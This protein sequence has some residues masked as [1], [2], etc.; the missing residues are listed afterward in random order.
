M[1]DCRC[2]RHGY[3][4]RPSLPS[5]C[6][7]TC[8]QPLEATTDRLPTTIALPA[9]TGNTACNYHRY[10]TLP[11]PSVILVGTNRPSPSQSLFLSHYS[12]DQA[13]LELPLLSLY[14]NFRDKLGN[15]SH[16][17]PKLK[18]YVLHICPSISH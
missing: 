18:I 10:S 15:V 17:A 1:V 12:L 16:L 13:L 5:L 14:L 11:L 9:I 6:A 4:L 3:S 2:P 8:L 7:T